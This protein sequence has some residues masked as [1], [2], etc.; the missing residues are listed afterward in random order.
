[1]PGPVHYLICHGWIG[2]SHGYMLAGVIYAEKHLIKLAEKL[3]FF[4]QQR[5]WKF[6]VMAINEYVECIEKEDG[7][8]ICK[9]REQNCLDE[10]PL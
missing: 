4:D 8:S 10:F 1:V 5:L 3:I 7:V 2:F 6:V 9:T